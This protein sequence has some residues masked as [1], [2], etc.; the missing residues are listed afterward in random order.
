MGAGHVPAS[1]APIV[2]ELVAQVPVILASRVETGP[3]FSRTYGFPG[4]ETDLLGRGVTR[5]GSLSALKARLLLMLL[6]RA[7]KDRDGIAG[8][9]S[10]FA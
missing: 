9:F 2:S 7:G 5:A 10:G 8:A 3:V 1:I 4:S 6:L